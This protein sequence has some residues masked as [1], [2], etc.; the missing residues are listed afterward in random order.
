MTPLEI[1]GAGC[2]I[3]ALIWCAIKLAQDDVV[4]HL[5][6]EDRDHHDKDGEE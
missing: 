1:L 5:T 6:T 4:I 2:I 3:S